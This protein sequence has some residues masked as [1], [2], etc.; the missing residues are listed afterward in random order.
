MVPAQPERY[1]IDHPFPDGWWVRTR[2]L[3]PH[4]RLGRLPFVESDDVCADGLE[5][6]HEALELRVLHRLPHPQSFPDPR[7]CLPDPW[8]W[9]TDGIG[10]WLPLECG[11]VVALVAVYSGGGQ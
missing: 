4:Y 10:F 1:V 5:V 8:R 6:D 7:V 9:F 11:C 3:N 2:R